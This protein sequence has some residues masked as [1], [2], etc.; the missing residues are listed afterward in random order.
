MSGVWGP[1]RAELDR[2]DPLDPPRPA[3]SYIVCSTPRS[4]SGLLC[5]GLAAAGA[6]GIPAEYFNPGQ[7][8]PLTERWGCDLVPRAYADALRRHRTD[9]AGTFGTKLHWDQLAALQDELGR[10]LSAAAVAATID[11]LVPGA[12]LIHI[13]R[14]DLTGQAVSLWRAKLSGVW[15]ERRSAPPSSAPPPRY[16]Y[17]GILACRREIAE[18]EAAWLRFFRG[19][20]REPIEVV[21]E[22]L[23][24]AYGAESA[25]VLEAVGARRH[26]LL[27]EPDG[28]R[29]AD[30]AS[31]AMVER[32]ERDDRA[33]RHPGIA[34]RATG[35]LRRR[36]L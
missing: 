1:T 23:S 26:E 16:S 12:T 36:F 4:G 3:V 19:A 2:A 14:L 34:L 9:D 24:A 35:R 5:R 29:Q 32:F 7:R 25:R 11:E 8:V 18:Q 31:A 22:E 17:R 6:G 21:Y 27:A 33:A 28:R 30:A 20:G 15:A 13:L 10:D